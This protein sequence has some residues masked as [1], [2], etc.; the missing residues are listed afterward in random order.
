MVALILIILLQ[1]AALFWFYQRCLLLK[2]TELIQIR[3]MNRRCHVAEHQRDELDKKRSELV[4]DL[5]ERAK[6]IADLKTQYKLAKSSITVI[7]DDV[8]KIVTTFEEKLAALQK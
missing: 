3:D 5:E 8:T 7:Y 6:Q 2:E 1:A 4:A